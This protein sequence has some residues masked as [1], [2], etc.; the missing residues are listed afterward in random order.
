M[1]NLQKQQ[2]MMTVLIMELCCSLG[3]IINYTYEKK[4]EHR[5]LVE[6]IK[7]KQYDTDDLLKQANEY[8]RGNK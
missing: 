5:I 8:I 1:N 2:D 6:D 7:G 4:P 3:T